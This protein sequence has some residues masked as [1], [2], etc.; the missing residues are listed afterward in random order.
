[1]C[2]V[3][4]FIINPMFFEI[5]HIQNACNNGFRNETAIRNSEMY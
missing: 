3:M 2:D 4:V 5:E 1:M